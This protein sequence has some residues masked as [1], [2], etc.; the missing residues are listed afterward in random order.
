MKKITSTIFIIILI[1]T[2]AQAQQQRQHLKGQYID[3]LGRFYMQAGLPVYV[4]VSN[5][6]TDKPT[7]LNQAGKPTEKLTPKPIYLD[8][9]GKHNLHHFDVNL[10]RPENFEIYADGIAPKTSTEFNDAKSFE[11]DK[12]FYGPGLIV[13]ISATDEMSGVKQTYYSI[14]KEN[15]KEYKSDI[16]LDKE[17][18]YTLATYTV[19]NVGNVEEPKIYEFVVDNTPPKTY[20]NI[21][22]LA[23]NKIIS[24]STKIYLTHSDSIS[25]VAKTYYHFDD[26][27]DKL[28]NNN[29]IP[30]AYLDDGDHTLTF[31]SVDNVGNVEKETV[32][33]FYF[34]KS[35]PIMSADVLGDRFI[36]NDKVYFSGRTK[37][38]LTAVD[39]KAGVKQV[40]YT[41]DGGEYQT[42]QDPFYL[43][44]TS[45]WHTIKYFALDNVGNEGAGKKKYEEYRHNV[46]LVY[47]D[48]TGP[49]MNYKYDGPNFLKGD[50]MYINA[51]T[52]IVLS[53]Q[54]D[55]S[56][57]QKIT[58]S[59]DNETTE[60]P[61]TKPFSVEKEGR[62][63]V[64]EISYDNVNNR[65]V[66]PYE[67]VVD[68]QGPEIY[69]H[70]NIPPSHHTDSLDIYPSYL[71][72]FLAATDYAVGGDKI[73]YNINES[74]QTFYS[75]KIANFE[76]NKT[77]RILIEA[78]DKLGN[79]TKKTLKFRT[80][81]Y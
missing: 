33:N 56:G 13:K 48:L 31:H 53:A 4:Y 47:V 80:D 44:G 21:V 61:Y 26:E 11:K 69:I 25:G 43:P 35:A 6:P 5:S 29:D 72:I 67:F 46:G 18:T 2:V 10:Q 79:I 20:Y 38:K 3:S 51:K 81:K 64:N 66:K 15:Y 62:H 63:K 57:L 27:K 17:G 8:G 49:S 77:Y 28:Y 60:N 34:D 45:G 58:Y 78:T 73:S 24:T 54:D 74:K 14:N 9:H 55:E 23:K 68:N 40:L 19:D 32:F 65:N 1:I 37:L 16:K 30:F 22:G 71:S 36:V 52:K 39:N 42:Y 59:V 41:V 50:S 76:K 12:I 70:Y 7:Q 75:D